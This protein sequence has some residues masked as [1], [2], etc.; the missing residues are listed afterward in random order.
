VPVAAVDHLKVGHK[1][2]QLVVVAMVGMQSI[3]WLFLAQPIQAAALVALLVVHRAAATA[4]LE[5]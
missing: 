3:L 2:R 4:V 5:S 1:P